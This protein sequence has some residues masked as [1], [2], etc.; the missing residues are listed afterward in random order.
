MIIISIYNNANN[1][2][3]I[4]IDQIFAFFRIEIGQVG[5]PKNLAPSAITEKKKY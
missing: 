3:L 1:Y 4:K 2:L 5:W